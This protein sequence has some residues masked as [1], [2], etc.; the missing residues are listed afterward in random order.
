[1]RSDRGLVIFELRISERII[2]DRFPTRPGHIGDRDPF[3]AVQVLLHRN[4]GDKYLQSSLRLRHLPAPAVT[5][6]TC[7]SPQREASPVDP[8]Q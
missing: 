2:T 1:M 6:L 8:L 4:N 5:I 7:A 3:D